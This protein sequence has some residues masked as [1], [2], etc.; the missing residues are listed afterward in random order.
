MRGRVTVGFIAGIF[1]VDDAG[2]FAARV[3][4]ARTSVRGVIRDA[5]TLRFE[6]AH[7]VSGEARRVVFRAHTRTAAEVLEAVLMHD[8]ALPDRKG[9]ASDPS[10]SHA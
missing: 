6:G 8:E 2:V 5:R 4:I 7:P 1:Y 9:I 3:A 10:P